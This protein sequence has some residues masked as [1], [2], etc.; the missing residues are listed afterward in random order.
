MGPP[1]SP[2][3][4]AG[5]PVYLCG[6]DS[7]LHSLF[8]QLP[9]T[10]S[11]IWLFIVSIDAVQFS[12]MLMGSPPLSFTQMLIQWAWSGVQEVSSLADS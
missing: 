10:L 11:S 3:P 6:E 2:A 1:G 9:S 8:F 5:V 7:S 12:A 4:G